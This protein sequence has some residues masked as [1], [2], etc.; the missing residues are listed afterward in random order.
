[1]TN[2]GGC[3]L[4]SPCQS[5]AQSKVA[6]EAAVHPE[7]PLPAALSMN[8]SCTTAATET[9]GDVAVNSRAYQLEMLEE[10]LKRNIIVAVYFSLCS[11]LL[12]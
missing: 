9:Q 3:S 12:Y 7:S 8:N 11:L 1:M 10:S 5:T 2:D 4:E 6:K